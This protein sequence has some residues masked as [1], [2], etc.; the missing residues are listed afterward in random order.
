MHRVYGGTEGGEGGG[1]R[2]AV[3]EDCFGES[4]CGE[5]L[6]VQ[7]REQQGCLTELAEE[8]HVFQTAF[9]GDGAVGWEHAAQH[10]DVHFA[11]LG[12]SI[13]S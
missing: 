8:R 9:C 7:K 6:G 5:L 3:N 10:Q 2:G 1:A 12:I 11:V 4:H 13:G